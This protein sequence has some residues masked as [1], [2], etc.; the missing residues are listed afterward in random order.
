M[1]LEEKILGWGIWIFFAYGLY[2]FIR[3]VVDVVADRI[4]KRRKPK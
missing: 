3:D 4:A 1:S 2:S